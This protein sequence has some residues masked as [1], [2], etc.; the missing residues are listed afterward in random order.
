[1]L[2]VKP[3]ESID[4]SPSNLENLGDLGGL[5]GRNGCDPWWRCANATGMGGLPFSDQVSSVV[6][7]SLSRARSLAGCCGRRLPIMGR[8]GCDGLASDVALAASGSIRRRRL[9]VHRLVWL[10]VTATIPAVAPAVAVPDA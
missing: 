1:M 4:F 5:D 2:V 9:P 3:T 8:D 7:H 6:E 10:Y